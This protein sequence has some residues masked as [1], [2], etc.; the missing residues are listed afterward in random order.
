MKI[1]ILRSRF[2]RDLPFYHG[3]IQ[4]NWRIYYIPPWRL[5][6]H[7]IELYCLIYFY[8]FIATPTIDFYFLNR[9][10]FVSA[11]YPDYEYPDEPISTI[12]E[13]TD[14][15]DT[16]ATSLDSL[17]NDSFM[18]VYLTPR[19]EPILCEIQYLNGSIF[20]SSI[21][22][23]DLDFF[24]HLDHIKISVDFYIF[25]K[26]P[27]GPGCSRWQI[28][29]NIYSKDGTSQF[30]IFPSICRIQCNSSFIVDDDESQNYIS[31]ITLKEN[32]DHE[33]NVFHTDLD[34]N[35]MNSTKLHNLKLKRTKSVKRDRKSSSRFRKNS[36][37]SSF[38]ATMKKIKQ[39]RLNKSKRR[40]Q[41]NYSNRQSVINSKIIHAKHMES[42]LNSK[43]SANDYTIN[44]KELTHEHVINQKSLKLYRS[45]RRIS[46]ILFVSSVLHLF[47]MFF[48][49]KKI[50]KVHLEWTKTNPEYRI[51]STL[52]Q[53]HLTFGYWGTIDFLCT[54]IV[55][56]GAAFLFFD[57]QKITQF[58]SQSAIEYFSV[59]SFFSLIRFS[60]WL[61]S[62]LP[63]YQLIVILREAFSQLAYLVISILPVV[64]GLCLFGIFL[65]G[66]IEDSYQTFRYLVQR[67]I[68]SG[69]GDS[70]DDFFIVTDDGTEQ[71]AW[72]SFFYV[73]IV[74]ALGFW[75]VFTSCIATVSFVHQNYIV[76]RD[77]YWES[78][79]ES[80][81]EED[82]D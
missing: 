16:V 67:M 70:I 30:S 62:Y 7:L 25:S 51:L 46:I 27:T 50:F 34:E 17:I 15:F 19:Q 63:F 73:G 78:S 24:Y 6:Y 74:T 26:N 71:T 81:M 22:D 52:N 38:K 77:S 45:C 20:Y 54:F 43:M 60:Q 40:R 5:I 56:S 12:D 33:V 53:F 65:F 3:G 29:S 18:D 80:G 35:Q 13:I 48:R 47:I 28:S 8:I 49:F 9:Q 69:M 31:N 79:S 23:I 37:S 59:A 68:T 66:F 21:P 82:T 64:T 4:R 11:F 14:Y 39:K 58:P 41:P 76:A 57:S 10:V 61:G 55:I 32:N 2:Q 42:H 72:L 44:Q 36:P 75:I 1:K